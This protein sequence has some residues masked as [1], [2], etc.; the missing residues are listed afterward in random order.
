MTP[1]FLSD[2]KKILFTCLDNYADPSN[3]ASISVREMLLALSE[4]GWAVHT[5]CGN[6]LN[7]ENE[8]NIIPI[9][10][11]RGMVGMGRIS[12]RGSYPYTLFNFKDRGILSTL[13]LNE[14]GLS[15]PSQTAGRVFLK[16]LQQTIR[17]FKPDIVL[18][19]GG[20][21]IGL[22]MARLVSLEGSIPVITLR[23]C[24]YSEKSY[25]ELA[26][27]IIVPSEF[28]RD[29]YAKKLGISSV[30][31]PSLMG[32]DVPNW[33]PDP[34]R[35]SYITFVNPDPNKGFLWF[36]AIAKS[37]NEIRPDIP[38]LLVEGRGGWNWLS[39]FGEYFDGL[40]NL[41]SMA[42]TPDPRDFYDLTKIALVPS[43]FNETFGR[44][45]VEA[46]MNGIPSICSN[47]GS[48]PE[49]VGDAGVLLDIPS[50]H[51]PEKNHIPTFDEVRP[52]VDAI[53]RLWDD[54]AYYDEMSRKCL[55]R[56]RQ[57]DY[58]V[59][60]AQYD[61]VLTD[62]IR[63]KAETRQASQNRIRNTLATVR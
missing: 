17:S 18:T 50:R 12:S 55:D 37:M 29:F 1:D 30:P 34:S 5:F 63:R 45:P 53:I 19:Y 43:Y 40:N 15:P 10:A 24:A 23:N 39:K 51:C 46:M 31:I 25:C 58:D 7:F 41:Y 20:D 61:Q 21:W 54:T 32:R 11:Q 38:F 13:F 22:P 42:N 14:E 62:L 28:S 4:R 3:G 26:E 8:T 16:L 9:L 60:A 27:L 36:G 59:V 48:L 56:A 52:W 57:W 35:R 44:V 47:R 49:V 33:S 2:R 6:K